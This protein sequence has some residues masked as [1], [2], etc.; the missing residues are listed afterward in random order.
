VAGNLVLNC[1]F[2]S[3]DFTSWSQFGNTANNGV[4]I[5]SPTGTGP[6]SG[7]QLAFFGPVDSTGGISQDIATV[8][9]QTYTISFYLQNDGP[10]FDGLTGATFFD[11]SFGGASLY[12]ETDATAGAY[13]FTQ[14]QFS[15]TGTG[16]T[17]TLAFTFQQNPAFYSL[18]DVVVVA[19]DAAADTPEPGTIGLLG[20]G[21]VGFSMMIRRRKRA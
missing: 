2:E 4:G 19:A 18:D 7:T 16:D 21:L 8:A 9:G 3:T 13:P 20:A 6:N 11:V 10:N 14:F 5:S 12:S 15:G 1:G 17:T